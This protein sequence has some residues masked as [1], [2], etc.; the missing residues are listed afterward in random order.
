MGGWGEWGGVWEIFE[1]FP[2]QFEKILIIS[3]NSRIMVFSGDFK[4]IF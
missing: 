4:I 1:K 2:L 3:R